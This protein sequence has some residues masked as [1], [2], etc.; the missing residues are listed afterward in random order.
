MPALLATFI[1]VL[2]IL[3]LFARERG[4]RPIQSWELW[5]PLLWIVILGSRPISYWFGVGIEGQKLEDYLEGSPLDRVVFS[6]LIVAGLYVLLRRKVDWRRIIASN[7]WFFAF[8]VYCGMSVMWSDY[9]LTAFKRYVK[10]IGNVVMAIII[11][12]EDDSAETTKAIFARYAYIV[13]PLS[14]LFIKYYPDIGR[15]YDR[16]TWEPVYCGIGTGKN[17]LGAI[18]MMSGLF[19]IYDL[20]EMLT[21]GVRN[22]NKTDLSCRIALILMVFWLLYMSQ[23]S[24]SLICM[25]VGAGLLLLLRCTSA[26]RQ[27]RYLGTYSLITGV[28][29]LFLYFYQGILGELAGVVGRNITLTGRTSIWGNLLNREPDVWSL[30]FGSGFESFWLTHIGRSSHAGFYYLLNQAHNGYLETYLQLG[31]VGLCLLMAMIV[32]TGMKLKW[33]IL[34]GNTH[35]VLLLSL[36]VVA[37]V[38]NWTEAIFNKLNLIWMMLIIC[39][40]N[41]PYSPRS[42]PESTLQHDTDTT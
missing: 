25:I 27:V 19:L 40:L 15:Y 38:Y 9:S 5:V 12:T 37:L 34:D 16:W 41:D 23:S 14:V 39:A 2:F 20:A 35:G 3:F 22:A 6:T 30:L 18:V 24:T 42:M 10:E 33:D 7:H 4:L 11:L 17:G 21:E 31:M 32:A 13:I 28:L 1:C 26:K 8:F 29:G 36:F